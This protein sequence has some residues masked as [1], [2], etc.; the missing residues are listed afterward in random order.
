MGAAGLFRRQREYADGRSLH[1]VGDE[2]FDNNRNV[3]FYVEGRNLSDRTYIGSASIIDV[4]TPKLALF[5]P[6]SGRAV[7]AGAK[8]KW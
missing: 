5:E 8:F 3:S 4:A 2:G 1:A 7:F 6:G